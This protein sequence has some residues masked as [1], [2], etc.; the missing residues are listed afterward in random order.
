MTAATDRCQRK[1]RSPRQT[2]GNP[3]LADAADA[4]SATAFDG[5]VLLG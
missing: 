5:F 1:V 4:E 2:W 3:D